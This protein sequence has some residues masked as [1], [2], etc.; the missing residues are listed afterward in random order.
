M[1]QTALPSLAEALADHR[2]G[3]LAAAEAAYRAVIVAHPGDA[4]CNHHLG[5]LLVQT[6]RTDEGLSHLRFALE[7]N[8]AEPLYYF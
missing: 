6:G 8:G 1:S 5:V 4:G 7:A 3:R 2:A